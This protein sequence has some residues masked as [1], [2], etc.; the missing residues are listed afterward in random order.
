ML[1]PLL[2]ALCSVL[3]LSA[4]SLDGKVNARLKDTKAQ[5][6]IYAKNLTTGAVYSLRGDDT[7][8]TAS[9]IKL[10]I[11]VECFFEA[12]TGKLQ[13]TEPIELLENEKVNGSGI[14]QE[15]SSGIKLPLRDMIELMIVL[16]DNTATNLILN[17]IGG[18]AVNERMAALGLTHTRVMRKILRNEP[19]GVTT[20]GARP[21]NKRWGLG[22]TSPHEMVM[23]LQKLHAG[24]LVDKSS[25]DAMLAVLKRQHDRDGIA[26][27]LKGVTVANK[28]GAL[29]ALRSDA[30]IVFTKGGDIAMD[31]T[32]DGLPEPNWT[33]ENPGLLLISDLSALL[34][35]ALGSKP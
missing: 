26:R 3:S 18:N 28:S 17:R 1:R 19:S 33:P 10:P 12:S 5:V 16:S 6:S 13:L 32:V 30:G 31:I 27:D 25:S 8:R 14:L 29:D 34:V 4:S 11:M 2:L 7:V 24:Q 22:R 21:E 9:T 20:D 23:L 35:E 15:L